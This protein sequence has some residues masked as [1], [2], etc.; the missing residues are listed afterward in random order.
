MV[1][2]RFVTVQQKTCTPACPVVAAIMPTMSHLLWDM[3]IEGCVLTFIIADILALA[4]LASRRRRPDREPDQ[5]HQSNGK[6]RDNQQEK[7]HD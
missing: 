1:A 2:A 3:L 5:G 7:E 4:W 6:P